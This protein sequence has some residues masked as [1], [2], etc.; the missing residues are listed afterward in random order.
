MSG[1]YGHEYE[2]L[3]QRAK[4]F[5]QS[6]WPLTGDEAALPHRRQVIVWQKRAIEAGLLHRS[7]PREY[8]GGGLPQDL[9]ADMVIKR[10]FAQS[11]VPYL[12]ST[13]NGPMFLVPALL[14]CGTEEQKAE[15]IAPTLSGEMDWCQGYSEP[16]AGSDLAALTS[17]AALTPDG[18]VINGQKIWTSNAHRTNMMFGVFRTE[19]QQPRHRG[20][21]FLIVPMDTPGIDVRVIRTMH[22]VCEDICEVFFDDVRIPAG[23]IIGSRGGGWSVTKSVLKYERLWLADT[24]VVSGQFAHLVEL[25]GR[26]QRNGNPAIVDADI[27]QRLSRIEAWVACQETLVYRLIAAESQGLGEKMAGEM[28]TGKLLSSKIQESIA[29]LALDLI[30]S[31]GLLTPQQQ[32]LTTMA[33]LPRVVGNGRWLNAYFAS[34]ANTLGGGTSNMQ[35]NAIGEQLLGLPRDRRGHK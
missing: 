24:S 9:R 1:P 15:Y 27:R 28:Q 29:E 33:H 3:R 8:G 19:P 17:R 26:T 23:N 35:R 16:N 22:G 5:C 34:L 10:E 20:V 7:F 32:D 18:W 6:S 11:D 13:P 31:D 21:S 2:D 12:E 4:A 14:E 25:A 30:G